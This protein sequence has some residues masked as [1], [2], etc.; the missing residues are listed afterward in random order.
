MDK[1][2]TA[3][4]K[5]EFHVQEE[6][7]A[8]TPKKGDL[9][10]G[11]PKETC[12]EEKRVCLTPDA[13]AAMTLQGHRIIIESGAGLASNFTDKEYSD[14]GA[15]ISYSTKE[16]FECNI[17][18]KVSPPSIEEINLIKPQAFLVSSLQLKTQAKDYFKALANKRITAIAFDFIKD[19]QDSFPIVKSLS[20]IAGTASILIASELMNAENGGSGRLLG[21]IS[22]VPPCEVVILGA[23][24]V[25]LFAAKSAKALGAS[26]KVFDNSIT[27]L[28][29]LQQDLNIP[30][31]TSTIHHKALEK[32][33]MRADVVIGAIKGKTRAPIV[34][35]EDL[36]C[37]MK[38]G[39]VI[40]DVSIDRGGCFETSELTTHSNPTFKKHGVIH[41]GVPN[42]PSRY[43]KTATVSISNIITPYLLAVGDEGG[44]ETA[45][46]YDTVIRSGMYMYKGIL[47]KKA[48]GD[49]FN[50]PFTDINLLIL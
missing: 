39:A 38:E 37:V 1:R 7:L 50:I 47:T 15:K 9:F 18:L 11:L 13:V 5:I 44:F 16:V 25:A 26:V 6:R 33:L 43:A 36:I 2:M 29:Q 19:E 12:H 23:G 28:R 4:G 46:K 35:S 30:V 14:S 48:V 27:K 8:I 20:E 40:I 49:W 31:Y 22:G 34:V 24:T 10:I 41:Y 17:V 42:I 21:N 3:F 32:A 45:V